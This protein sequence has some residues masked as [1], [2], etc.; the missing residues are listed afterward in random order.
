MTEG[1]ALSES[2]EAISARYIW[3]FAFLCD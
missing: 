3:H 1:Q 2:K